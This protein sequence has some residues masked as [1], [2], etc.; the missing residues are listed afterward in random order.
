LGTSHV[1]EILGMA[2][3]AQ[4]VIL[5]IGSLDEASGA[6]YLHFNK[7]SQE[8]LLEIKNVYHG[9]GEILSHVLDASGKLCALPYANRVV[10]INLNEIM[11]IPLRIGVAAGAYKIE[12]ILAA[13]HGG[14]L[15]TLITDE[16]TA[17]EII[18]LY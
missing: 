2:R 7:V 12:P 9:I 15:Q 3:K 4:V 1:T 17:R 13:L 8:E 14:F 16:I 5:G 6:S 10:G 18:K 11:S